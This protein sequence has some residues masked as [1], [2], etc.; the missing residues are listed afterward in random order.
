[1]RVY[2]GRSRASFLRRVGLGVESTSATVQQLQPWVEQC[3]AGSRMQ[4][5]AMWACTPAPPSLAACWTTIYHTPFYYPRWTHLYFT[6]CLQFNS[7]RIYTFGRPPAP[8][9]PRLRRW[10]TQRHMASNECAAWR[11]M[12]ASPALH[13]Q[14]CTFPMPAPYV[15]PRTYLASALLSLD[16]FTYSTLP[17]ASVD[18]EKVKACSSK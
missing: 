3:P 18:T 6:S 9:D 12:A 2:G 14:G 5:A 11:S 1:M 15:R 17:C 10:S 7:T 8:T 13:A 16:S 4:D